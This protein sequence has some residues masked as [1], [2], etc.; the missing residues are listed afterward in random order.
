MV[1]TPTNDTD[2]AE[3]DTQLLVPA[4]QTMPTSL[5]SPALERLAETTRDYAAARSSSNTQKA[6]ASDWKLFE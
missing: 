1:T 4:L 3:P 5:P 6:Y 2:P